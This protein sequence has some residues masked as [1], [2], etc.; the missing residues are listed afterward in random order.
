[1]VLSSAVGDWILELLVIDWPA[2]AVFLT[3]AWKVSLPPL[4]TLSDPRLQVMVL[5][6]IVA[7]VRLLVTIVNWEGTA[8]V[9]VTLE[10]VTAPWLV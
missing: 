3:W 2:G 8:S 9:T 10:A 1:M 4:P 5:P 6:E 7:P